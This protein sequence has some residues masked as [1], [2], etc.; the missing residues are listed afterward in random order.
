MNHLEKPISTR[1]RYRRMLKG[2]HGTLVFTDILNSFVL[3]T[4]SLLGNNKSSTKKRHNSGHPPC[5]AFSIAV[6]R[7]PIVFLLNLNQI[8]LKI[9]DSLISTETIN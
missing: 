1:K 3:E 2:L 8:N 7:Q 4:Q 5:C 6:D 9:T